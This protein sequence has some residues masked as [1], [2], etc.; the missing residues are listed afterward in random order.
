[1]RTAPGWPAA[2]SRAISSAPFNAWPRAKTRF[3]KPTR[4]AQA[5]SKRRPVS[6]SS[7][8]RP[9]PIRRGSTAEEPLLSS[10]PSPTSGQKNRV[11]SSQTR[12]SQAAAISNAPPTA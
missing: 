6:I 4:S 7:R 1:M 2:T 8:V 3:T 11:S 5:A 12:R 10:S 9:A